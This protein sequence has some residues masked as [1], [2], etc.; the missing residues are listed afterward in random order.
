MTL[1]LTKISLDYSIA[2]VRDNLSL[3]LS[4]FLSL[5][6]SLSLSLLI[7][8]FHVDNWENLN[9]KVKYKKLP[10]SEASTPTSRF[11]TLFGNNFHHFSQAFPS[12][13]T[14]STPIST[15]KDRRL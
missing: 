1:W 11:I 2:N 9:A 3:S 15:D 6:L 5:S 4:L 7:K 14:E 12:F 8:C 13:C 10:S